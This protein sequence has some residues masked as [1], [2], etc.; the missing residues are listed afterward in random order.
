M[1][2]KQ[3]SFVTQMVGYFMNAPIAEAD[4]TFA[5]V[6]AI[7]ANRHA[8]GM[9]EPALPLATAKPA[10]PRRARTPVST[11]PAAALVVATDAPTTARAATTTT[12]TPTTKPARRRRSSTTTTP[13]VT[14]AMPPLGQ[15]PLPP[16][17]AGDGE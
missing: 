9:K 10:R 7:L 6:Q 11:P 16:Q 15:H 4:Q 8:Q 2:R 12:T 1:P 14:G 3:Q 17:D 5:T 13:G